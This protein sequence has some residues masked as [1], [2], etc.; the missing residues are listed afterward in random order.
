MIQLIRGPQIEARSRYFDSA[1]WNNYEPRSDDIIIATYPKC[2]TTWTQRIVGMLVFQSADPFPV[3]DL[4]PWPDF[5]TAGQKGP[6]RVHLFVIDG[7]DLLLTESAP[8]ASPGE[9]P[10]PALPRTRPSTPPAA[11]SSPSARRPFLCI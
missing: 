11:P 3:Q 1:G 4:S 7:R 5:A 2:G 6:Q 8:L 10:P 9:K